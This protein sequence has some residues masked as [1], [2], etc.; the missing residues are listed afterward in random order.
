MV[1]MIPGNGVI[2]LESTLEIT[3]GELALIKAN[4]KKVNALCK[5]L[6]VS[7][8]Y[9]QTEQGNIISKIGYSIKDETN[10]V[11]VV[12]ELKEKHV[13]LIREVDEWAV[14]D[15]KANDD[16]NP[17]SILAKQVRDVVGDIPFTLIMFDKGNV[18]VSGTLPPSL[19]ELIINRCTND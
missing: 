13:S 10:A 19:A 11:H 12:D 5:D 6:G 16:E 9:Y 18:C 7:H 17:L 14:K 2:N 8:T 4:K 1:K 15:D 3:E